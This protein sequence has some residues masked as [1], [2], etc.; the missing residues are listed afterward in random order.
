[1]HVI[2]CWKGYVQNSCFN[3]FTAMSP[4]GLVIEAPVLHYFID[5]DHEDDVGWYE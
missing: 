2:Y 3:P 1:M 4:D 5:I